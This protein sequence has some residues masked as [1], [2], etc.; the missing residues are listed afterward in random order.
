MLSTLLIKFTTDFMNTALG[1]KEAEGNKAIES[2]FFGNA[3]SP[4]QQNLGNE[5]EF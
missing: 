1:F 5:P 4:E 2:A 3:N